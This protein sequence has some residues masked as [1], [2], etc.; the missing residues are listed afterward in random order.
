MSELAVL[1][2]FDVALAQWRAAADIKA[3]LSGIELFDTLDEDGLAGFAAGMKQMELAPG[4]ILWRQATPHDGLYVLLDGE[5]QVCRQLPGERELE[6]ARLGPGEVV[7]ELPLL[8]GG[9]HSATVRAIDHC[10]V[11]FLGR[12]L[13]QARTISGERGALELRRRIVAIACA[14]LRRALAAL[15]E[16]LGGEAAWPASVAGE[17]LPAE[18]PPRAYLSRLALFGGLERDTLDDL[19]GR[20]SVLAA[21]RGHVLQREGED[22]E[23]C[24]ITLNGAVE[25][26]LRR[27]GASVRVGFAG[28]GH[29]LGYVGLLDGAAAPVTSVTRER[30]LLLAVDGDHFESLM[31]AASGRG[32]SAAIETDLI[33]SL[34]IAARAQSHLA[35]GPGRPA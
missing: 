26:V 34:E 13:F 19:L 12:Q 9:T 20:A 17:P 4:E 33:S 30:C 25:D 1:D 3:L 11:L 7:G 31:G 23:H 35:T 21:G 5:L 2:P 22:V 29:A 16:S 14:R 8:G 27:G 32:F 10:S 24:Y 28:P 6:L 15:G 18:L